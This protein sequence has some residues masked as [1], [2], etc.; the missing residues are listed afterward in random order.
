MILIIG[1]TMMQIF[2]TFPLTKRIL[3]ILGLTYTAYLAWGIAQ[4]Q[5]I[6]DPDSSHAPLSFLQGAMFQWLNP[7][8]W[9]MA[10]TSVT[11]YAPENSLLQ[12]CIISGAFALW[13]VPTV[14]LWTAIGARIRQWLGTENRLQIFN[15]IMA[16][17][18]VLSVLPVI[19][20]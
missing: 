2:D 20:L 3:K 15:I 1:M 6:D 5:S 4:T 19:W 7:K 18:L 8:A 11:L 10:L 14:M 13:G 9:I 16:L 12:I 17:L